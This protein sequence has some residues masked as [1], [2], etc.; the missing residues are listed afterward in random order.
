MISDFSRSMVMPQDIA[1]ESKNLAIWLIEN[2][3]RKSANILQSAT[4]RMQIARVTQRDEKFA[5]FT[6]REEAAAWLAE[7]DV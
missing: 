3:L 5:Y 2:G 7:G 1:H 6:S 4:Q